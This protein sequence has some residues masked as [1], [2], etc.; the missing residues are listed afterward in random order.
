VAKL[1][2]CRRL[3]AKVQAKLKADWSPK[4]ISVWLTLTYP[5]DPGQRVVVHRRF[6]ALL[7]AQP[8]RERLAHTIESGN[9]GAFLGPGFAAVL[10]ATVKRGLITLFSLLIRYWWRRWCVSSGDEPYLRV[11]MC[12]DI[13]DT[14][15]EVACGQ[16]PLRH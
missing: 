12:Q 5:N 16:G 7:R 6:T 11:R 15:Q 13:S 3:R 14:D 4:E 10:L 1:A 8:Q 9:V 2:R